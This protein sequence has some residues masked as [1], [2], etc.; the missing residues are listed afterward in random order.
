MRTPFFVAPGKSPVASITFPAQ[1]TMGNHLHDE[2]NW[3]E[4]ASF[5]MR[6]R[7]SLAV[8]RMTRAVGVG[9]GPEGV[10]GSGVT[11]GNTCLR[12]SETVLL[13]TP[14][15]GAIARVDMPPRLNLAFSAIPVRA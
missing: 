1:G 15:A 13:L 10:G 4:W 5:Q 11:S 12:S 14:T 2:D 9:G 8:T 7:S 3:R 6:V